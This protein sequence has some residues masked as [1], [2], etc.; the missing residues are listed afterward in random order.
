MSFARPTRLEHALDHLANQAWCVL[1]GGTDVY[2]AHVDRRIERPVLDISGLSELRSIDRTDKGVRIGALA[3]WSDL[4]RSDLPPA[5]DGLKQA[6]IEVGSVQI[7]NAGTV[8]GNLCNASPAADGVPPLLTLDASVELASRRERR[9][10]PLDAFLTG[11][12]KTALQADE[13]MTA[14]IIPAEATLGAS[15]FR[16]LGAR[17]YLV[18]SIVM[19]AVRLAA[20]DGRVAKA[21]VAIGACS[22]VAIR[23]TALERDLAGAPLDQLPDIVTSDHVDPLTPIDDVRATAPYRRRAALV[24]VRRSLTSAAGRL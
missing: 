23:L 10:L 21:R 16:K 14:I 8:A 13:L 4:L 17:K 6:A 12:R 24:L 20:A 9:V 18:I 11:Y 7:Q 22:P 5:F 15:D 19:A 3:R 1:A 2:P